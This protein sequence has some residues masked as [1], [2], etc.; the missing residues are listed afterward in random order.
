[1]HTAFQYC[2]YRS[3]IKP[4]SWCDMVLFVTRNGP[5]QGPKWCFLQSDKIP[6]KHKSLLF[7]TL[8]KPI[9]FRVF[10]PEGKSVCKYSLIFRG[11]SGN[12][13]RKI[14]IRLQSESCTYRL[15]PNRALYDI[16]ISFYCR[17][18]FMSFFYCRRSGLRRYGV[19]NCLSG[20][21]A[22]SN[23]SDR[24]QP[25]IIRK[26]RSYTNILFIMSDFLC[27]FAL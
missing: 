10:A 13:D 23:T 21:R 25:V 9:I 12:S 8:W 3:A 26:Y 4:I 11:I 19:S 18:V 17:I 27:N 7:N 14:R 1:M 16:R 6:L 5:F 24:Q 20:K 22:A 15:N 2:P